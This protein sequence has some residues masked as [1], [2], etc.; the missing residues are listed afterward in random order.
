MLGQNHG[1][2]TAASLFILCLP[3][4]IISSLLMIVNDDIGNDYEGN[5]ITLKLSEDCLK[6][7]CFAPVFICN[8][9]RHLS[10]TRNACSWRTLGVFSQMG[11]TFRQQMETIFQVILK[12]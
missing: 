12:L 6:V 10:Q 5:D 11:F 2:Q 9:M 4:N 3:V 7:F 1:G 8:K